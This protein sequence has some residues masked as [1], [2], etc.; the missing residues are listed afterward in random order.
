MPHA[1]INVVS[2]GA[3]TAVGLS[4][5]STAAAVRG[6]I[7]RVQEHERYRDK[8]GDP[9]LLAAVPTVEAGDP[10]NRIAAVA[11]SVAEEVLAQL[12]GRDIRSLPVVLATREI[13]PGFDEDQGKLLARRVAARL[14]PPAVLLPPA[15]TRGNAA[16][17]LALDRARNAIESGAH[18]LVLVIGADSELGINHLEQ[19]DEIGRLASPTS[20]WGYTPGEGAG[21]LL[22]ASSVLARQLQLP[23]IATL[24]A[25]ATAAEPVLRDAEGVC[26]GDGLSSVFRQLVGRVQYPREVITSQY[27]DLNGE[28]YR[29]EEFMYSSQR[30]HPKAFRELEDFVA[31]ADCWGNVGAA[32]GPLQCV[33]AIEANRRS[34]GRG[35]LA[36]VWS[37]SEGQLRG[38]TLLE[39]AQ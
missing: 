25:V 39:F 2:I 31:P 4:A 26:V 9:M 27:C 22:L 8:V 23:A 11:A 12:E 20:K 33:L 30:I 36:M 1:S 3:C 6:G 15:I 19:L 10:A 35:P 13:R 28:R 21:A 29:N 18:P 34:Y 38:G 37:S 17:F 24:R 16:G 5:A 7:S 14:K 32:S